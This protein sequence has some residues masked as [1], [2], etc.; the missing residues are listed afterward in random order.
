VIAGEAMPS[1]DVLVVLTAGLIAAIA[2]AAGLA[3]TL[4]YLAARHLV[5]TVRRW[6]R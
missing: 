6:R 5:R 2:L 4:L 1:T 3:L